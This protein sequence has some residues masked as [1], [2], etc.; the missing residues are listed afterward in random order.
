[1]A[2]KRTTNYKMVRIPEDIY[3]VWETRKNKIQDRLKCATKKNKRVNL[4]EVLR[5]YGN[6]KVDIW[7]DELINY[8]YKKNKKRKFNGGLL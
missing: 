4:T 3:L 8:F 6:R 7:D 2:K 5:Y 1:M